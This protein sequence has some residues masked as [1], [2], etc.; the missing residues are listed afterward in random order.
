MN[1]TEILDIMRV[2]YTASKEAVGSLDWKPDK[3]RENILRIPIV[4][5]CFPS[6]VFG[7]SIT[8]TAWADQ[9]DERITFQLM[10]DIQGLDYRV[11]RVDWRPRQPHTNKLGP[12][13]LRGRTVMTS[14]HD[15]PE[16][17]TVGLDKM[18]SMNLPIA[19]AIEPEPQDF[20]G[21]LVYVR[22]IFHL[23]NAIDIPEP[24]WAPMLI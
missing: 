1:E 11:A 9:P 18:Q 15:F 12:P 7:V 17:A 6:D 21:L 16:N 3:Q 5:D 23:Q 2:A 8:G 19:K 10:V 14:V 20:A 24:P 4:C 13:G 22:D